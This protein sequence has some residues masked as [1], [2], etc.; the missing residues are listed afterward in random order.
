MLSAVTAARA[1]YPN[2]K[3]VATGHSLGGA[4][5][6]LAAGVLRSQ[7]VNVDLVSAFRFILQ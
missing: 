1:Q 2:F 3:I 5:A 7:S 6:S 4:L